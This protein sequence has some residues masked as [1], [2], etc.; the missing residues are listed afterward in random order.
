M[1][2]ESLHRNSI[3]DQQLILDYGEW[4]KEDVEWSLTS[5]MERVEGARIYLVID[6]RKPRGVRCHIL[7][8]TRTG[9]G[10]NNV[11]QEHVMIADVTARASEKMLYPYVPI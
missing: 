2:E 4:S 10:A 1:V 5:Q 3:L 8:V 6:V 9:Q 7:Y 11:G